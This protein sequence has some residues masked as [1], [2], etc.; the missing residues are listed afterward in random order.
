MSIDIKFWFHV[1][2]LVLS[3]KWNS[4]ETTYIKVIRKR[5]DFH[6][7]PPSFRIK[8]I[9]F[10]TS[11]KR[12]RIWSKSVSDLTSL[13]L[14]GG[15]DVKTKWNE[16][17]KSRIWFKVK[18]IQL[19]AIGF[20]FHFFLKTKRF[21][22]GIKCNYESSFTFFRLYLLFY[23]LVYLFKISFENEFKIIWK[24]NGIFFKS[25]PFEQ[26]KTLHS[27][28]FSFILFLFKNGFERNFERVWCNLRSFEIERIWFRLLP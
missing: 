9:V 16:D 23:F 11:A 10:K 19:K 14:N 17:E 7:P 13:S 6:F 21:C 12:K 8:G 20:Y 3:F 27:I 5:L 2:V 18:S 22:P 4:Q 28:P 1:E 25:L 15:E 24:I 26:K